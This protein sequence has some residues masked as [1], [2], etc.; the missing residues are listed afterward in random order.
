V[1]ADWLRRMPVP[2]PSVLTGVPCTLRL[3]LL[4]VGNLPELTRLRFS[5]RTQR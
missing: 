4:M 2:E 5:L 1:A 3:S